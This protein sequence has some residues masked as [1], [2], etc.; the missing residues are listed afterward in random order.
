V[1]ACA[2]CNNGASA[3]DED[4]RFFISVQVGKQTPGSAALWDKG[5]YPGIR[6]KR[7]LREAVL[8]SKLEIPVK[9]QDGSRDRLIAFE[10]PL[11]LYQAVFERTTR[12]LFFH[13]SGRIL[14]SSTRV[15]VEPLRGTRDLTG[16]L[17]E[18]FSENSIGGTACVY[19]YL[20]EA[21]FPEASLWIYSFYGG[22]YVAVATGEAADAL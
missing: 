13:H 15:T 17:Y 12:G 9:R 1:P 3:D 11:R 19:K 8:R 20:M 7:T 22:S 4:I 16:S 18:K 6:R 5:A 10:A 2:D 14:P 21:D